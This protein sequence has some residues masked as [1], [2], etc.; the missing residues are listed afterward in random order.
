LYD[1]A[2]AMALPAICNFGVIR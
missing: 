1:W 2:T